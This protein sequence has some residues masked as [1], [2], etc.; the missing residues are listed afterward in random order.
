MGKGVSKFSIALIFVSVSMSAVAQILLKAG[1]SSNAVQRALAETLSVRTFLSV[2]TNMAV[3]SGLLVYF[4][5]ALLWLIV[6]SK[7]EV[8]IAYPFVAL[9]FVLTAVMGHF[10]FGELL[11]MPRIAGI[12]L[13]CS[14][15]AILARG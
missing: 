3:L 13:V 6:L 4:G 12:L 14:G 15:V 10:L 11:T 7:V 5:A 2:F 9:G 8:T 1:M